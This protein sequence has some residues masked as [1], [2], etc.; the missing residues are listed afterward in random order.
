MK[1]FVK[2]CLHSI[3]AALE[4]FSLTNFPTKI[5]ETVLSINSKLNTLKNFVYKVIF[6]VEYVKNFPSP[7]TKL[8]ANSDPEGVV[9]ENAKSPF[10]MILTEP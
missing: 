2:L 7:P 8:L 1:I 10:L 5:R 3:C 6:F 4:S 9:W